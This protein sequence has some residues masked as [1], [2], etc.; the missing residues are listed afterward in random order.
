MRSRSRS[1][2]A[3]AGTSALLLLLTGCGIAQD[4]GGSSASCVGPYLNDQPPSG[5]FH[6]PRRTVSPGGTITI[7][8]HWYTATCN[9]TGGHDPLTPLAPVHL[10]LRLPGGTSKDLGERHPHGRDMGFAVTVRVPVGTPPGTA[11]VRDGRHPPATYAF[12]V[13]P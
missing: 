6:G 12:T 10:T 11:T 13:G 1:H 5:A 3:A 8:G 9:D 2:R 7:H 4:P